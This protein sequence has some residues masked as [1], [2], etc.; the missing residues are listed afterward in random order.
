MDCTGSEVEQV[1]IDILKA[2]K[3]EVTIPV[4]VKV[5][6]FFTTWRT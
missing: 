6:P 2:V 4:A 3:S 5:S 1:Y